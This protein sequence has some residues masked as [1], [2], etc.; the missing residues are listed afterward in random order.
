MSQLHNAI[1]SGGNAAM[2]PSNQ[3]KD[4]VTFNDRIAEMTVSDKDFSPRRGTRHNKIKQKTAKSLGQN[5]PITGAWADR[6]SIEAG[7]AAKMK[8]R[9]AMSAQAKN[10][11]KGD[12]KSG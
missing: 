3:H 4:C 2:L 6:T 1:V 9:A 5:H 7:K 8:R 11:K 12:T 10:I